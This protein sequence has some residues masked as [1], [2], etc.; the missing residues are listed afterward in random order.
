M[1][2]LGLAAVILVAAFVAPQNPIEQGPSTALARAEARWQAR[3]PKSYRFGIMLTCECFPKGMNF[4]VVGGQP[5]LPPGADSAS[6]RFHDSFGT[7]ER[8]FARI[9]RAITDGGHRI[10]V[11]YDAELGYPIWADLD[12]RR[13][14][15]DDELFFRVSGFQTVKM[16]G[17][18][19]KPLQPT[20]GGK[21]EV[22]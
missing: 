22:E 14:V 8:L 7:I 1:N 4:R 3:G 9:R 10:D 2:M 15:I 17:L 6:Q 16:P 5:Q 12:P 19:N 18:P 20:S 21:I 13:E 11:K